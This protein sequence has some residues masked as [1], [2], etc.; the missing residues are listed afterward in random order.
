M[1]FCLIFFL[2]VLQQYLQPTLQATRGTRVRYPTEVPGWSSEHS[3]QTNPPQRWRLQH[4]SRQLSQSAPSRRSVEPTAATRWLCY[5]NRLR[6]LFIASLYSCNNTLFGLLVHSY[7]SC[8]YCNWNLFLNAIIEWW[9]LL[10]S[11]Y[12]NSCDQQLKYM[13]FNVLFCFAVH[14]DFGDDII[15]MAVNGM[16]TSDHDLSQ[17]YNDPGPLPSINTVF[18]T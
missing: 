5:T 18:M 12:I 7:R 6:S 11:W 10:Y 16:I 15:S 13:Y 8:F 2:R 3:R 9:S 14:H 1:R 4:E 17:A